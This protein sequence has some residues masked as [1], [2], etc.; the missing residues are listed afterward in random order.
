MSYTIPADNVAA[1]QSGHIAWS[2]NVADVLTLGLTVNVRNTAYAGGAAG[3]GTSDDTAAIQAAI[4]AAGAEGQGGGAVYLPPGNYKITSAL[5]PASGVR[6]HGDTYFGTQ[7][8]STASSI[9]NM[10]QASLVD[11]F[12]IDH[13][14]LQVTNADLFTGANVARTYIHDCRLIQNTAGNAIW[15]ANPVTLMIESRFLRNTEYVYGATRTIEAWF[16]TSNSGSHQINQN[17]W[18]DNVCFNQ[19]SDATQYWYHIQN[20]VSNSAGSTFRNIV[21]EH[22]FGGM[23]WLE[24]QTRCSIQDCYAYDVAS[25]AGTIS[26]HLVQISKN[27]GGLASARNSIINGVRNQ[28][29]VTFAS[30]IGDISLDSNC[31]QTTII[32]PAASGDLAIYANGSTGVKVIN[33]GLPSGWLKDSATTAAAGGNAGTN[34]PAPI[35]TAGSNLD[36]GLIT[37]GSGTTPAAGSMVAVTYGCPFTVTPSAILTPA[38]SATA[39]L[40][41]YVSSL[42]ASGFT[43]SVQG[44]PAGTQAATTYAFRWHAVA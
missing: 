12:E 40:S 34:P 26:N 22:P 14:T 27:A 39:A 16:L 33:P 29:G 43:A 7:I 15:N 38:N 36:N 37:F 3:N 31:Q 44:S 18:A 17:E 13:L 42:T 24:S 6:I 28:S 5:N 35:V 41:P 21:F 30:N 10:G 9:F 2:N 19:N 25:A 32:N 1:G 8:V 4:T 11:S 23:I 20:T